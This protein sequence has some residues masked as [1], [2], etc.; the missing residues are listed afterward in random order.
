MTAALAIN[1]LAKSFGALRATDNLTFDVEAN[2]CHAVLGPNGAGKSTLIGQIMGEITPDAG[3]IAFFGED[4]TRWRAPRRALAGLAR[5]FQITQLCN[6]FS[7]LDNV[8]FAVQARQGH[9]Y[10][11]LR[12]AESDERLRAPAREALARV[13]LAERAEV[14]ASSLSHG[15]R[16]QLE[17]AIAIAMQP[18]MLI[19]DEPMAGMGPQESEQMIAILRALRGTATILLVEHDMDAVFALADRISVLV[20][21]ALLTTGTPD[22]VRADRAVRAAYLGEE[23]A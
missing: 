13:G 22:A 8:A 2:E 23:M 9:S 5:S 15:E 17:L 4:I 16:R 1:G 20:N 11:F 3:S 10:R 7:A 6:G 19:L 12:N 18:R 14:D 21:G